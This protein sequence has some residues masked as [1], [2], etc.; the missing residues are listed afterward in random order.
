MTDNSRFPKLRIHQVF[1]IHLSRRKAAQPEDEGPLNIYVGTG[2][3]GEGL[4]KR[5]TCAIFKSGD[6]VGVREYFLKF[7]RIISK[8]RGSFSFCFH[9][10]GL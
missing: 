8:V 5:G 4:A 9:K 10:R 7:G 6:R 1:E 3:V 2:G